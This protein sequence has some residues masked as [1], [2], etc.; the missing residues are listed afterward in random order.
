MT[1]S[2]LTGAPPLLAS[3]ETHWGPAPR[4][5]PPPD[6][7]S[8][9]SQREPL[10]G[11]LPQL[12]LGEAK[13]IPL[14]ASLND[15]SSEEPSRP[16]PGELPSVW[17]LGA[18]PWEPS[19]SR[20]NR[21]CHR[22]ATLGRSSSEPPPSPAL[23]REPP[24]GLLL[25]GTHLGASHREPLSGLLLGGYHRGASH[26]EPPYGLSPRREHKGLPPGMPS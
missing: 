2:T 20:L 10:I 18:T 22:G 9:M 17:L 23:H 19:P 6:T 8:E 3:S 7:S 15:P 11:C 1:P 12:L 13:G 26:R 21:S 25:G 4:G 5:A 16:N 14:G 24:K